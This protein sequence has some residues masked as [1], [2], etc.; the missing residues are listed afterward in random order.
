MPLSEIQL[1][2]AT[3]VLAL[4]EAD[5][6]ALA[7]GAALVIHEA[8][9]RGT[10][11]LD[12]FGPS[13][14]AVNALV[15]PAMAALADEGLTVQVVVRHDGFA[16][17]HRRRRNRSHAARLRLRPCNARTRGLDRR[18]GSAP[19][20]PCGRQTPCVVRPRRVSR[21]RGRCRPPRPFRQDDLCAIARSKDLGFNLDVLADA[22]GVLP[23]YDRD[24]EYPALT[25]DE[26]LT[27]LRI[28]ADWQQEIRSR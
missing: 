17:A 12:C 15:G 22:F 11:D 23:R 3:I 19:A 8:V 21:L 5:G 6:F 7:G 25:D 16:K 4:P 2:A 18:S 20:R 13:T 24:D 27:L 14:D 10:K 26:H 9:D 28:F 1:R